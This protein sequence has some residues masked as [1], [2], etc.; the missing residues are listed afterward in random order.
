KGGKYALNYR[1][2]WIPQSF[3]FYADYAKYDREYMSISS[4]LYQRNRDVLTESEHDNFLYNYNL[5][6]NL[7]F[8]V[9]KSFSDTRFGN[10]NLSARKNN[11]WDD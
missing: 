10:L 6:Q 9:S 2:A 4:H 8:S 5:K 1:Y 11:Y 7:G 3:Y